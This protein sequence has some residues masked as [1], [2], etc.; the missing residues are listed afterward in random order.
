MRGVLGRGLR[1][2]HEIVAI[3]LGGPGRTNPHLPV[4]VLAVANELRS[5][6]IEEI[7][8]FA[9]YREVPNIEYN[10]TKARRL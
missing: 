2:K 9:E 8:H 6:T 1:P 10:N 4:I 7:Q 3:E 5:E